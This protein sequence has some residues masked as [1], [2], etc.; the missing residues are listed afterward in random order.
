V[1]RGGHATLIDV[2]A[3][4]AVGAMR[5]AGCSSALGRWRRQPG[6]GRGR[7]RVGQGGVRLLGLA[8]WAEGRER[9]VGPL[10][11]CAW[12]KAR[13][14]RPTRPGHELGWRVGGREG[15]KGS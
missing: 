11:A 4:E 8:T 12:A 5:V 2:R 13:R 6:R 10:P 15:G 1:L 3:T 9:E 7:A 14:R